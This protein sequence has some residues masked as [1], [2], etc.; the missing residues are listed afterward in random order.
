MVYGSFSSSPEMWQLPYSIMEKI[1]VTIFFIQETILSSF[2]IV[3][4]V[5]L[6]RLERSMGNTKASRRLMKHLVVVNILIILLDVTILGLEYANE[7]NYQTS[8]KS[9][10]YS[11]KLKL[12]FT[13][14]NR[15]VEMT[16]GSKN[17]SSDPRSRNL[18]LINNNNT[19]TNNNAD[20]PLETFTNDRLGKP[21][22]GFSYQAYA[23][24]GS[25]VSSDRAKVTARSDN[26]VVMTT[27]ITLHHEERQDDDMMSRKSS[28]DSSAE[29]TKGGDGASKTS[30]Q[31]NIAT[32][33]F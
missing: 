14:L 10:V 5:K 11:T 4:T 17:A 19:N 3:E 29:V 12:E 8:Y 33:G 22:T 26:R 9:F 30:S 13:I 25:E 18:T 2:Y 27:E 6:M 32:R 28:A 24:G 7:Y 23:M 31:I 16:T 20:I 1:Q 21:A 15:L